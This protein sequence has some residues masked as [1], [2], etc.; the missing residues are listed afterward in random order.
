MQ[1]YGFNP[2]FRDLLGAL[3]E[4]DARYLIVGGYAFAR[5]AKPRATKDFDVW[6]DA[7]P[8]NGHRV[9]L[10]LAQ[11]GTPGTHL[12]EEDLVSPGVTLQI[13][14]EPNR[15]DIIT[16]VSGLSFADAW[17]NRQAGDFGGIPTWYIGASDLL[18]NK[19]VAGRLQDQAD[20][21]MLQQFGYSPSPDHPSKE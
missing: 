12:A 5:Y 21:Q 4:A 15:I 19:L 6:V 11:F 17:P 2:D 20:A 18:K 10:A 9:W 8:D 13:G 3:N 1:D 7:S 14:V 16:R